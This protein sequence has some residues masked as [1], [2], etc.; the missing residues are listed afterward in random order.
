MKKVDLTCQEET[1][2][3][4]PVKTGEGR[5]KNKT[6]LTKYST[7]MTNIDNDFAAHHWH[8]QEIRVAFKRVLK[9]HKDNTS[10]EHVVASPIS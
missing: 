6:G 10:A 5:S 8:M 1:V 3:F 7:H 2:I 9:I 4:L